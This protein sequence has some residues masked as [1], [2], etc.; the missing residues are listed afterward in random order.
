M[1]VN[2]SAIF[3][4]MLNTQIRPKENHTAYRILKQ[5]S[6]FHRNISTEHRKSRYSNSSNDELHN[7]GAGQSVYVKGHKTEMRRN[8]EE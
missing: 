4:Q 5:Q 6:S 2:I 7:G 8:M 1:S 3:L